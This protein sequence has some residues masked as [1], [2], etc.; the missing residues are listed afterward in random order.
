[1]PRIRPVEFYKRGMDVKWK[2]SFARL[3]SA[4]YNGIRCCGYLFSGVI[5][6]GNLVENQ[7]NRFQFFKERLY[8]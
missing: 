8:I 6:N 4:F 2:E 7:K 5:G 1:M 3:F